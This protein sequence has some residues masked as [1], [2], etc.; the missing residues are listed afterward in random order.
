MTYDWRIGLLDKWFIYF[1]CGIRTATLCVRY[2]TLHAWVDCPKGIL[3]RKTW[4]RFGAQA[5]L[6]RLA[7]H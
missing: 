7:E 4:G 3:V 5:A 1:K 6:W 2:V